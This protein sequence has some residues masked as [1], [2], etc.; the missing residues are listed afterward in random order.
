MNL[1][2]IHGNFPG[3]FKDIAPALAQRSGGR[4]I[5]LTLSE[6]AQGI[7]LPGVET[8]LVKLHRDGDPDIHQYLRATEVAILKGQ[9]ILRE[10]HRLQKEESFTPDV[11]IC[12]GGMGFGSFVKALLPQVKL[13]SYMEWFF[14]VSNSSG[15]FEK[16]TL[17]D[18]LRMETR[19]L[20]LLQEM[21]QADHIVCPTEWQR[22]QFP[23]FIRDRI[24]VIFDGVDQDFFCPG[25]SANPLILG[26][27]SGEAI[28][29]TADQL[30]LT[31][32]T[33]GMEPLRGFPEFMRAAAVAQQR[34]PELQ[35]IVFGNDRSAYSYDS[36]HPS[37][38][39]KEFM[40]EELQDELDLN[41]LHFTGLLTYG[42]LVQLFRR[43][44]L[45]CYFTRPYVVSWGVFQAAA[46][47]AQLLV[48]DFPGLDEVFAEKP[49]LKPV[50]LDRQDLVTTSVIEGLSQ[51]NSDNKRAS[52][53]AN[54]LELASCLDKWSIAVSDLF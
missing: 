43:S 17:D 13:I 9:A 47:G 4:T 1:L 32:G 49:T 41:R 50:D 45:H 23:E 2:F 46:C 22:R 5:F 37:G 8:R 42:E 18:Q 27:H 34:F 54:G 10:L 48:N 29:F 31:Y 19:N 51:I 36:P 44:N 3:Q 24:Q 11:V 35:V 39:W 26:Q 28:Q 25:P 53:L 15:L 14:T 20:P 40:L 52:S 21:V 33:R 12:H 7:Q 38:S 16:N 6:N 30:L